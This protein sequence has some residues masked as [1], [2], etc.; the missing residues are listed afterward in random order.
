MMAR[1]C[2]HASRAGLRLAIAVVGIAEMN[3]DI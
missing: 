3:Q 2:C 1:A